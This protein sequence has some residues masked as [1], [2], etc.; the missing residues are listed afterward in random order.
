VNWLIRVIQGPDQGL[1]Q[2]LQPGPNMIGRGKAAAIKLS[3]DDVSWEHAMVTRDHDQCFLENLSALGT[4]VGETKVTGR[5][6][7]RPGDKIRLTEQTVLRVESAAG[8]GMSRAVLVAALAVMLVILGAVAYYQVLAPHPPARNWGTTYNVLLPWLQL[9][10]KNRRMPPETV[11]L[12]HDAWRLSQ[13]ADWPGS[14]K[15]WMRLQIV[16]ASPQCKVRCLELA[17]AD[18]EYEVVNTLTAPPPGFEPS[19]D[20]LATALG[21][22]VNGWL[23][24][25]IKNQKSPNPLSGS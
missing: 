22:F 20:Q 19:D 15:A 14:Q 25:S 17:A 7:V 12:F 2:T 3:V 23:Q 6:R 8:S 5:V 10:V 21:D 9:Q 11:G 24:Q 18:P 4:W 1:V 13:A 16:L